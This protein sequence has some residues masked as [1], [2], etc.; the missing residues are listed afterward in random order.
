[1]TQGIEIEVMGHKGKITRLLP[2]LSQAFEEAVL[3]PG[4]YISV[5]VE[6]E[7][8]VE[9]VAGL[10]VRIP[11]RDYGR[12]DLVSIVSEKVKASFETD[13]RIKEARV[14]REAREK[15]LEG[16]VERVKKAVGLG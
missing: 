16:L 9:G 13:C 4:D 10:F 8:S 11:G 15:A 12:T 1:M 3:G 14:R 6:F 2:A 7:P 5:W